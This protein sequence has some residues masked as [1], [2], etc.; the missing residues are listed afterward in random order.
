MKA[1]KRPVIVDAWQWFGT[2]LA[3]VK[4]F[5][6]KHGINP[7]SVSIGMGKHACGMIIHTLEG[8]MLASKGDWIIRGVQGEYYPCKPDIFEQTYELI[9]DETDCN[10]MKLTVIIRNDGPMIFCGDSPSYRSVQIEL[11]PEQCKAITC[12]KVGTNCGKDI[13]ED[14]SKVFIEPEEPSND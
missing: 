7:D 12:K 14:I 6:E 10:K 4:A 3:D 8:R 1:R 9:D 2:T 11:T 5:A 13:Y